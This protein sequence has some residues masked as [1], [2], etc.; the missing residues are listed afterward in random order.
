[1]K[2]IRKR[3]GANND[4]AAFVADL[5]NRHRAKRNLMKVLQAGGRP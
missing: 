1:M 3:L 4:H 2:S 5:R